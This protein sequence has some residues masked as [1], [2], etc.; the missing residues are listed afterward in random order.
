MEDTSGRDLSDIF[1]ESIKRCIKLP[2]KGKNEKVDT[3]LS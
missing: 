1:A 3:I 2:K